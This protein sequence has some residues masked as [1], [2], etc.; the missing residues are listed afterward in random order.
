MMHQNYCIAITPGNWFSTRPGR[1]RWAPA[2]AFLWSVVDFTFF[3]CHYAKQWHWSVN[4]LPAEHKSRLLGTD[5]HSFHFVVTTPMPTACGKLV[6]DQDLL[7]CCCVSAVQH[8]GRWCSTAFPATNTSHR[9]AFTDDSLPG[10]LSPCA[11]QTWTVAGRSG[12]AVECLTAVCEVPGSNRAVGNFV[13]RKSHCDV[14][15]RAV[16]TFPAVP[17]PTQPSTLRG[18]VNE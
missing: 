1:G 7:L 17:R 16:C 3:T 15:P 18:T 2:Y 6:A 9:P 11:P 12:L 8:C 13:Y 10:W 14:Q 5:V 4:T